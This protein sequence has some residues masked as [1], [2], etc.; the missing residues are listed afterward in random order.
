MSSPHQAS[1]RPRG[2]RG[3]PRRLRRPAPPGACPPFRGRLGG[4][5]RA[6]VHGAL[7]RLRSQRLRASRSIRRP[8][9]PQRPSP[10]VPESPSGLMS[11]AMVPSISTPRFIGPGCI[12][13]GVVAGR[14]RAS[15]HRA[16]S[17]GNTPVRTARSR[18][19]SARAGAAASSPRRPGEPGL[20]VVGDS[21]PSSAA[22]A[23]ISV[24]G[25][26]RRHRG[27]PSCPAAGCWTRATRLWAM[28]PPVR[29]GSRCRRFFAR[30]MVS[31]SSRACVGCSWRPSPALSTAQA[32]FWAKRSTAPEWGWRTTSRWGCMALSAIGRVDQRFRP[33]SPR[34]LRP[35]CSSRRRPAAS[36]RVSKLA[37]VRVEFSRNMLI[38]CEPGQRLAVLL[39]LAVERDVFPRPDRE[40][41]RSRRQ[42][43]F[44]PQKMPPPQAHRLRSFRAPR[45]GASRG[46]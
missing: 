4:P 44:D 38:W 42:Q 28:S 23:G 31:A 24:G 36:P 19:P 46:L 32:T 16:R 7:T 43:G 9:A 1:C 10:P 45:R 2:R 11:S 12:N 37:W 13:D 3:A 22:P 5:V 18:R 39:R 26:T 29:D 27:S 8:C 17:G 34:R 30:R 33:S 14:G 25:P 21:T 6:E 41:R 35:P 40:G 15:P 20:H